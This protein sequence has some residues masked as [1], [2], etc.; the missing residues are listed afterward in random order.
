MPLVKFENLVF[1]Y[2]ASS[3]LFYEVL[4]H[5]TRW[6]DTMLGNSNDLIHKNTFLGVWKTLNCLDRISSFEVDLGVYAQPV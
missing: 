6:K 1:P 3:Y 4:D 2:Q 5:L